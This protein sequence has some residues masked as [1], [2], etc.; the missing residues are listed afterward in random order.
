M[1]QGYGQGHSILR[2]YWV[3]RLFLKDPVRLGNRTYRAWEVKIRLKNGQLNDPEDMEVS[4]L[5]E[6]FRKI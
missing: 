1:C 2:N 4:F 3:L 5:V 6:S